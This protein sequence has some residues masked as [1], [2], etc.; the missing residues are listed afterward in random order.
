MRNSATLLTLATLIGLSAA[1]GDKKSDEEGSGATSSTCV[2]PTD[3]DF[4]AYAAN[5]VVNPN[6]CTNDMFGKYQ[7][8]GFATVTNNIITRSL[9]PAAE[10]IVGTSF[11]DKLANA[12]AARQQEFNAHL[13]LFLES[14][15][16]NGAVAYPDSAPSMT[17]AHQGL[18]ITFAQY[19][20]FIKK[21]V[22]PALEDAGVTDDDIGACFAPPMSNIDVIKSVVTCK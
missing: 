22:V 10:S 16:S 3:A 5:N 6:S 13:K 1:C 8:A 9:A 20:G 2:A 17:T 15:Y 12:S 19:D 11:Q 21:V 14:V 18:E 4:A 7:D